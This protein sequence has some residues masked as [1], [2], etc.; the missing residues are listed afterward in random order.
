MAV[1]PAWDL[2]PNQRTLQALAN[3][4]MLA[5]KMSGAQGYKSRLLERQAWLDALLVA[6]RQ[7]P[8]GTQVGSCQVLA[9]FTGSHPAWLLTPLPPSTLN[10]T[11]EGATQDLDVANGSALLQLLLTSPPSTSPL[12]QG[13]QE[14]VAV[15]DLGPAVDYELLELVVTAAD[16]LPPGADLM[17]G[18]GRAGGVR[19]G[20]AAWL[21]DLGQLLHLAWG[22][23]NGSGC[24]ST[25]PAALLRAAVLGF[26]R[27]GQE[28]AYSEWLGRRAAHTAQMWSVIYGM[29]V[30]CCAVRSVMHGTLAV[31]LAMYV[32]VVLP[33][34]MSWGLAAR[35]QHRLYEVSQIMHAVGRSLLFMTASKGWLVWPST[36]SQVY[37]VVTPLVGSLL[38]GALLDCQRRK[39][40]LSLRGKPQAVR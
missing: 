19:E 15:A 23:G 38:V 27:P 7:Q 11:I 3:V 12:S 13:S 24:G 39:L 29:T 17:H 36:F 8:V 22:Q 26:N 21:A 14:G 34:L 2:A 20:S 1:A 18:L 35:K 40:F 6:G 4:Q 30:L 16:L 25:H 10:M 33:Y 5:R 31:E 32:L 37:R 9:I 28:R